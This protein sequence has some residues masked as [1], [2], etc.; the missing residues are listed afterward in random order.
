MVRMQCSNCKALSPD[1]K[2]YCGECGA[3]L[4]KVDD[5][6]RASLN[7]RIKK[8]IK[9]QLADQKVVEVEL[10]EAVLQRIT[11]WG[12]ILVYFAGIPLGLLFLILSALGIKQ[13]SDFQALV[14]AA[15][16]TVEPGLER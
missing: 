15:S 10:T 11:A 8:A 14:N 12:K 7:Q 5:F 13:I 4:H 9:E 16:K 3:E 6:S 2:E 1:D